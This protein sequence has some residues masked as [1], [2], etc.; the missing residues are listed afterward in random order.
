MSR[1][2]PRASLSRILSTA[3]AT[4]LLAVVAAPA[5]ATTRSAAPVGVWIGPGNDPG[6]SIFA[7][8]APRSGGEQPVWFIEEI[9]DDC[10]G[11][12][13]IWGGQAHME[14]DDLVGDGESYCVETGAFVGG[15]VVTLL[16]RV[17]DGGW[18]SPTEPEYGPFT[19]YCSGEPGDG[20]PTIIGTSADEKLVGTP[21]HDVIDGGGGDDRLLGKGGIDVLCGGDGR[22]VLKGGAGLDI[23]IGGRGADVIV[24]GRGWDFASGEDGDDKLKGNGGSDFLVGG[25]GDDIINGGAGDDAASGGAGT[26]TCVAEYQGTCEG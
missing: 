5:G 4:L 15:G 21:G 14:G 22:D 6:E 19:R 10:S 17:G 13:R 2:S 8:I 7:A 25:A 24:G 26:D 3:T 20:T 11:G 12:I 16:V 23:L 18:W 9:S 1:T